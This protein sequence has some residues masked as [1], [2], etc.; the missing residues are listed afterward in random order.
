MSAVVVLAMALMYWVSATLIQGQFFKIEDSQV[1][2][3]SGRALD[4]LDNE[5]NELEVK[6]TD[7]SNW[8]D[9][10]K[11]VTDH[12][13]AFITSNLADGSLA[14][15]DINF[16]LFYNVKGQLVEAKGISSD[17]NDI[18][19]PKSLTDE[20][21]SGSSLFA[22]SETS[23]HK[24]LISQ[25]TQPLLIAALPILK[26]DAT[27]PVHGTLV[28]AEFMGPDLVKKLA[29]LTHL[30]LGF[31]TLGAQNM[32]AD[33]TAVASNLPTGSAKIIR[34]NKD[35]IAGY[36]LVDDVHGKP[37]LIAR[38]ELNRAAYNSAIQAFY[39][40]L[41]IVAGVLLT[42][43]VVT[44]Y[45]SRQVVLRDRAIQLKD[46]FFSIA[47]DELRNPLFEIRGKSIAL[48]DRYGAKTDEEFRALTR[49]INDSSV[50]LIRLVSNFLDAV[51]MERAGMHLNKEEFSVKQVAEDVR[52]ELAGLA[53]KKQLTIMV[54][55]P[56]SLP[57]VRADKERVKQVLYNLVGN[58]LDKAKAGIVTVAAATDGQFMRVY[59]SDT[60][61][62]LEPGEFKQLVRQLTQS[63]VGINATSGS[64][65]N[66]FI[67][68]SLVELMGGRMRA[69]QLPE[70]KGLSISFTVPVSSSPA[71]LIIAPSNQ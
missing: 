64:N 67:S 32:P 5:E 70:G 44:G 56:E 61:T 22:T 30:D 24:G 23:V 62:V 15:L 12:N 20:F 36:R 41:A 60:G 3:N 50:R 58:A 2:S 18:R 11:F 46:Q 59:V 14:N 38:V 57:Q 29:D 17:G 4:A 19:V 68:K 55:V 52:E 31:Y 6:A 48:T 25:P 54:Q 65:L 40:Y 37:L 13:Q 28:F 71:N 33:V 1:Q 63:R 10:Y 35:T 9:D 45:F 7:W 34:L 47:S 26:S 49:E 42:L 8:D 39:V 53:T 21:A 43:V 16:M 66:M 27:G 69:E 51:R